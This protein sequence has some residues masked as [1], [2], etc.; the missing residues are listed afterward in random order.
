MKT[1]KKVRIIL[2]SEAIVIV[3]DEERTGQLGVLYPL[4]LGGGKPPQ[5]PLVLNSSLLAPL[6][7][8]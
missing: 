3:F 8:A 4:W 5:E 2:C 1:T 6:A 7:A